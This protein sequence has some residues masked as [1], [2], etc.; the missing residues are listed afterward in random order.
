MNPEDDRPPVEFRHPWRLAL[1]A[2]LTFAALIAW[3]FWDANQASADASGIVTTCA[4]VQVWDHATLGTV[5]VTRPG[6][7]SVYNPGNALTVPYVTADGPVVTLVT[8]HHSY[9]VPVPAGCTTTTTMSSSTTT[10]VPASTTT[11]TEGSTGSVPP[12]SSSTV[13]GS[14]VPPPSAPGTTQP[15]A[16]VTTLPPAPPAAPVVGRPEFTG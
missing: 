11:T 1:L 6:G 2:A 7:V 12:V 9:T 10:T 16:A 3:A 4:T 5:V 13:P 14:T 15:P 8:A